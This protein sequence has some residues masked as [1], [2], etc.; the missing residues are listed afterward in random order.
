MKKIPY[1]QMNN[2]GK[3]IL[4]EGLNGSGKT[5][6]AKLLERALAEEGKIAFYNH[7]PT[8]TLIGKVL[9]EILEGRPIT[10]SVVEVGNFLEKFLPVT[11][12]ETDAILQAAKLVIR[13]FQS[14]KVRNEEAKR[15]FLFIIDRLVDLKEIIEPALN[16]GHWVIQ[17]RYDISCYLHGMANGLDF[18]YLARRHARILGENYLAPN[19]IVFY[20]VP[21]KLAL[22]RL[23][24]SGKVIDLYENTQTLKKIEKAAR[25]LLSFRFQSPRPGSPLRRKLKIKDKNIKIFVVNAEPP[26]AEVAEETWGIIEKMI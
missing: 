12:S 25:W 11:N 15:Q 22:Q 14:G 5:T 18:N 21:V 19:V 26:I 20:W 13:Q 4:I 24:D 17:D 10:K 2:E 8:D 6:Q 1:S 7:E 9:R 23:A 3:F 16:Q